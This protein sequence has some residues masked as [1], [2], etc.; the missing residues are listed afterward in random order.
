MIPAEL[1]DAQGVA[2]VHSHL[3]ADGD[4][5]DQIPAAGVDPLRHGRH[6][7]DHVARVEGLEAEVGVVEVEV[8]DGHAVGQR[9]RLWS[10][11]KGSAP[12]EAARREGHLVS[13][14]TGYRWGGLVEGAQRGADRVQHASPSLVPDPVAQIPGDPCGILG[15]GAGDAVAHETSL[16]AW[17]KPAPSKPA[18]GLRQA[19]R[20]RNGAAIR[21]CIL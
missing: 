21:Y 2:Q 15:N 20:S 12:Y 3:V 7:G 16:Q 6:A 13:V 11:P 19:K 1:P 5:E 8:A 17:K 9:G 14:A 4:G 18:H 10:R